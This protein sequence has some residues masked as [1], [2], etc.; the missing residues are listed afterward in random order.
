MFKEHLEPSVSDSAR[1][2]TS[3]TTFDSFLKKEM[4]RL[5]RVKL[6]FRKWCGKKEVVRFFIPLPR[7]MERGL[8]RAEACR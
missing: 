1:L 5:E 2:E 7:S 6:G 3:V 8:S 4:G